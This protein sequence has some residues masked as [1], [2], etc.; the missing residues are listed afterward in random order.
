MLGTT[1]VR[2]KRNAF[3]K[4]QQQQTTYSINGVGWGGGIFTISAGIRNERDNL[5]ALT[6][7]V[8][9]ATYPGAKQ[10]LFGPIS[11]SQSVRLLSGREG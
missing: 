2:E 4:E 6:C 1:W 5:A 9:C 8:C 3:C 10:L 7:R 11:V